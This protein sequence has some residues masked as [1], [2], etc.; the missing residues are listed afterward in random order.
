[1]RKGFFCLL[2]L[3]VFACGEKKTDFSG[4]TPITINEFN[5]VFK[6]VTLPISI[7]DTS[8]KKMSD[9]LVIGRKALL[10]FV[11][12]SIVESISSEKNN[13]SILH[14]LMK[15]EKETEYYL[16]LNVKE[17]N[18]EKIAVLVFSKKNKFLDF[19]VITEFLNENKGSR[20]YGKN[21][22]I[23]KE[24]TFLVEENK[25]SDDNILVYEKNGWAF[26]ENNFRLIYFDSNKKPENKSI[27]NPI[28]TLPTLNV[29]SGDY[30]RDKKNFLSLRDF[31]NQPNKY[32]FF[33]HFEKKEGTCVGELKGLLNFTKNTATYNEKGD[34]CIIHFTLSGNIAKIKEE[35]NCGNH[36]DMT[37][38]FNDEYDKKR[39]PKNKK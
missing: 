13:K 34:P 17:T 11:P 7:N 15:I 25:M 26:T 38:Y 12:D 24:P 5:K 18:K 10:Q 30:V 20:H 2:L 32:Q 39:R 31:P 23:N 19:K 3:V 4:N 16:L 37:C 8:I 28:D 14:P 35:G 33:L 29:H 36:R 27:V 6:A 21:L 1:M 9:T 22:F